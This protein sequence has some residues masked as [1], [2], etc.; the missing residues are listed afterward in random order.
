[1]NIE[2]GDGRQ[3]KDFVNAAAGRGFPFQGIKGRAG[4]RRFGKKA[5]GERRKAKVRD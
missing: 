3:E 4:G 5:K 2:V 1:M